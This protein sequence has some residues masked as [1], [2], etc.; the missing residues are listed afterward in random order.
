MGVWVRIKLAVGTRA[1]LAARWLLLRT[2]PRLWVALVRL[3]RPLVREPSAR[4]ALDEVID[5]LRDGE[6]GTT[7]V[8]AMVEGSTPEELEDLVWGALIF[9]PKRAP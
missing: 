4:S 1:L 3:I 8:R 7:L 5:I 9:D 6:P 2:R